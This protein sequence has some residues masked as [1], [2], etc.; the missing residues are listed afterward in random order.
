MNKHLYIVGRGGNLTVTDSFSQLISP[1]Y[2][3]GYTNNMNCWW[4]MM[5]PVGTSIMIQV[6]NVFLEYNHNYW[7]DYVA[8]SERKLS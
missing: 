6:T 2:P 5:T 3:Y 7:N 1:G 8:I 4:T